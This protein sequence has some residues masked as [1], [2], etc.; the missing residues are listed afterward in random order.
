MRIGRALC[1]V[2]PERGILLRRSMMIAVTVNAL[3]TPWQ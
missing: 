2:G 1:S 3:T